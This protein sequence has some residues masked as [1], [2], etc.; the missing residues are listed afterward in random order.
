[1]PLAL[2]ALASLFIIVTAFS[3]SRKT[4]LA[5]MLITN[6][7]TGTQFILLNQPAT[8]FLIAVSVVYTAMLMLEK[9]LPFVSGKFFALSVLAAQTI[10]YFAVNGFT[11]DWSL[12]ALAGT[13]VGSLAMWFHN[14]IHL[15]ATML[16]MGFIWLSY[17]IASGAYGQLPG[18]FVFLAGSS[19]SL[20]F[21]LKAKRKGLSLETVEEIPVMIRRLIA[22]RKAPVAT[23]AVQVSK[24]EEP[25]L[26]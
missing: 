10:G 23:G 13:I 25:V 17:Q 16:F 12:L 26:V 11:P 19:A 4:I 21:L 5:S 9:F 7:L 24:V 18:E 20:Y 8:T 1:L 3:L 15:K 6:I 14:P 2:G 22:G